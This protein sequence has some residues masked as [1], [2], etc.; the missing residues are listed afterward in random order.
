MKDVPVTVSMLSKVVL[1][2]SILY[3][4]SPPLRSTQLNSSHSSVMLLEVVLLFLIFCSASGPAADIQY[5]TTRN[6]VYLLALRVLV[7]K[8]IELL[9]LILIAVILPE[10]S[11][12]SSR[13]VISNLLSV[14][15]KVMGLACVGDTSLQFL[16]LALYCTV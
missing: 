10:M 2:Y 14:L 4:V 3:P 13:L 7:A 9:P 11:L 12:S 6:S 8:G 15:L 1:P 16:T 5:H